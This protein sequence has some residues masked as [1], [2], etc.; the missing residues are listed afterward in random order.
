MEAIY[1]YIHTRLD[2]VVFYVGQGT[3]TRAWSK[4]DRNIHWKRT[5]TKYGYTVTLVHENLTKQQAAQL[6]IELI[7]KYRAISGKSLTNMTAGGDG[8]MLG[9]NHTVESKEKIVKALMGNK[10]AVGNTSFKGK[11]HTE[12]A[13]QKL[14]EKRALQVP[15]R[16]GQSPSE[17]TKEKL[18]QANL[19]KKQSPEAIEKKRLAGLSRKMSP[20]AIAK[21]VAK[22]KGQKRTPEQLERMRT[23][24]QQNKFWLGKNMNDYLQE[25]HAASKKVS[26]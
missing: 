17:E 21:S 23:A 20:E 7:A 13:K 3:D 26:P 8:G 25:K 4:S 14:R 12:E 16:L 1:V 15:P 19:G 5:V 18:R 24:Q 10:Y 6:E 22:R 11:K 2:G 9:Y